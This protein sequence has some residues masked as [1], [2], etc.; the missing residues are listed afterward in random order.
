MGRLSRVVGVVIA[1][2]I[3]TSVDAGA[4]GTGDLWRAFVARIDLGS[5]L[6]MRLSDGQRF[7]ATLVAV[8]D[9][10]VLVQP[11]TRVPVAVQP[12]PYDAIV[13]IE[14]RRDGGSGGAKA[15]AIGVTSG[16]GAFFAMLLILLATV[17]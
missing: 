13:S 4:Q 2:A 6:T 14:R 15:V 5:E 1:T 17:D 10:A 11:K 3:L 9:D 12:V 8:R 16:V 7:R